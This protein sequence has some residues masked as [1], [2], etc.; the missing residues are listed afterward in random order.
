MPILANTRYERFAQIVAN[1]KLTPTA[2][3]REALGADARDPDVNSCR[4]MKKP[5]IAESGSEARRT[6]IEMFPAR[7]C[8]RLRPLRSCGVRDHAGIFPGSR[9]ILRR[10]LADHRRGSARVGRTRR[11]TELSSARPHSGAHLRHQIRY[12]VMRTTLITALTL[13]FALGSP[14]LAQKEEST[15]EKVKDAARAV[16]GEKKEAQEQRAKVTITEG[17]LDM[18]NRFTAGEI[19]F[20]VKNDAN[21]KRDFQVA[22][23]GIRESLGKIKPGETSR[24]TVKLEPGSYTAS[25]PEHR[26]ERMTFKVTEE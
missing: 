15:T 6:V 8:L 4:W 1:G 2:A 17:S 26:G 10:F 20:A 3:Y 16:L 14:V 9:A 18:P 22:G 7:S 25:C 21:E 23:K 5:P 12:D 13:A 11:A 19:T 24:L